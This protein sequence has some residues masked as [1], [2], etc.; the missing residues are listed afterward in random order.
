MVLGAEFQKFMGGLPSVE[1][2][3]ISPHTD[4][5]CCLIVGAFQ[6]ESICFTFKQVLI[7]SAC[8]RLFESCSSI[9]P[10]R[11]GLSDAS[12]RRLL[13]FW[14]VSSTSHSVISQQKSTKMGF[15]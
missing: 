10:L 2:K 15:S 3:Y 12:S 11:T 14:N 7:T 5:W 9:A 1:S 13:D 6:V 8:G 4:N